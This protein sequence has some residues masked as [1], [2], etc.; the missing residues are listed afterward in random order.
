M[1]YRYHGYTMPPEPLMLYY[2]DDP[3]KVFPGDNIKN[4]RRDMAGLRRALIYIIPLLLG[5]GVML[6]LG[7]LPI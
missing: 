7:G 4:Y 3:Q 2:I 5:A 1:V 6:A